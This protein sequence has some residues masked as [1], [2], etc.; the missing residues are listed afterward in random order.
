MPRYLAVADVPGL[1]EESFRE[2]LTPTRKWRFDRQSWV[3]KA[4]CDLANGRVFVECESSDQSRFEAWLA[5]RSWR[6]PH[7]HEIDLIHEAGTV[8]PMHRRG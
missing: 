8:W 6:T 2:A 4:A 7:I 3:T 1:T 5:D